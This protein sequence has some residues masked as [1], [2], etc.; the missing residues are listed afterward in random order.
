VYLTLTYKEGVI[1][2]IVDEATL[3]D[4]RRENVKILRAGL[5]Q[6]FEANNDLMKVQ[7][8]SEFL[9]MNLERTEDDPDLLIIMVEILR[10]RIKSLGVIIIVEGMM[11]HIL[12]IIPKEHTPTIKTCEEDL[13]E[14]RLTLQMLKD[15]VRS[16]FQRIQEKVGIYR[17]H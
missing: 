8:K 4:L 11:Q 6:K 1:F 7:M 12:R 16:K 3:V 17:K 5:K 15:S 10:K 13:L 2:G 9:Q 14:S